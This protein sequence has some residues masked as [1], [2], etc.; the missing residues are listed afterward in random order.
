M[1]F[2]TNT[3]LFFFFLP[4]EVLKPIRSGGTTCVQVALEHSHKVDLR[5]GPVRPPVGPCPC[6]LLAWVSAAG[7]LEELWASDRGVEK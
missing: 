4:L 3:F 2:S 6:R 5:A 7:R 1:I